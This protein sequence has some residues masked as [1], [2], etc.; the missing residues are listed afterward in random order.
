MQVS[1]MSIKNMKNVDLQNVD[2]KTL[3]SLDSIVIDENLEREER[4]REYIKQIDNPYCYLD[5]G[6]VVMLC[7]SESEMTIND[8]M[9][10]PFTH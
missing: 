6:C 9:Q 1:H 7:F 8:C 5:G 3:V 10:L 4:I 2:K